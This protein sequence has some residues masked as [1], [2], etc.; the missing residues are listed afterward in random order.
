MGRFA[1]TERDQRGL[2]QPQ[3]PPGVQLPVDRPV[4][5]FHEERPTG[6]DLTLAVADVV[7]HQVD[8][9]AL[10]LPLHSRLQIK[11]AFTSPDPSL[12][13]VGAV[14]E[15]AQPSAGGVLAQQGEELIGGGAVDACLRR[16]SG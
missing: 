16:G 7:D 11:G 9:A 1:A 4:V 15:G 5:P 10:P 3:L 8:A 12:G 6:V 2:G 14:R 13:R